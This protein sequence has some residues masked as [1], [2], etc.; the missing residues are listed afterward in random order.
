MQQAVP[1]FLPQHAPPQQ[2]PGFVAGG[3]KQCGLTRPSGQRQV[4]WGT[5]AT[6]VI[7]AA[8]Q[9]QTDRDVL[10]SQRIAIPAVILPSFARAVK[11]T[12]HTR[13]AST[14]SPT[15]M[16]PTAKRTAHALDF[17]P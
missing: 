11:A 15:S 10:R 2:H 8:S 12:D 9:T 17:L 5:P 3:P 7:A 16:F 13:T 1:A 4:K 14:A 6:T